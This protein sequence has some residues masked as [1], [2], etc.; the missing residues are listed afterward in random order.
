LE[1]DSLQDLLRAGALLEA[2]ANHYDVYLLVVHL[3]GDRSA[4]AERLMARCCR[5]FATV[6]PEAGRRGL[7]QRFG[8]LFRQR[9]PDLSRLSSR[10]LL[11]ARPFEG[12]DFD[13][14][15][16]FRLFMAQF[17]VP[18]LRSRPRP[19]LHL[20]LDDVESETRSRL[21]ALYRLNGD[22]DAAQREEME[23]RAFATLEKR[24]LP[25]FDRVYVCSE[26]DRQ[27]LV[28]RYRCRSVRVA[29]NAVRLPERE[30]TTTAAERP[31]TFLFVGTFG[32]YPND[33]AAG[34]FCREVLP[35]LRETARGPFRVNV[36]G[37]GGGREVQRL[38]S[39]P[40]V[41][42]IGEVPDVAIYYR[43]SDAV[44]VP[45]RSGG[46]TRIKVLE[47]FSFERPV[48]ATTIGIEGIDAGDG[49]HA[50]IADTPAEFAAGCVRLMRNAGLAATLT[51]NAF[52][53][54]RERYSLE[55]LIKTVAE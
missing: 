54:V 25:T 29:P 44:I 9:M 14:V 2:L 55:A 38:G 15:H 50:V 7:L 48:V 41:T 3:Y 52:E 47:A 42:V 8:G 20:D 5:A 24:L 49:A 22:S 33:D 23:W 1:S 34:F 46:G 12:V 28:E 6:E 19:R 18:F 37:R 16:V 43:A 35:L 11:L 40:E 17:A 32:Y 51:T 30:P 45:V 36:V 4:T 26:R 53:L 13:T 31:F 10:S 27:K 39:W 21:A